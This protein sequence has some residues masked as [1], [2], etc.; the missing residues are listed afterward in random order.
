[1]VVD[2]VEMTTATHLMRMRKV[3]A[4]RELTPLDQGSEIRQERKWKHKSAA[5]DSE[6][7]SHKIMKMTNM[8]MN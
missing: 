5:K 3:I 8:R 6:I 7:Q 4:R 1:M 2:A